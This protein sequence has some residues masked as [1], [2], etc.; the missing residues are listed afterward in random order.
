MKLVQRILLTFIAG[1]MPIAAFAVTD[2]ELEEARAI[3]TKQYLRYV[4]NGSDYLDKITVKSVAEL[5]PQLKTKE[6]ENI[7]AFKQIKVPGDY[8]S[9]DKSQLAE[10][11]SVTALETKGLNPEGKKAR[12]RI[13]KQINAMTVAPPAKEEPKKEEPKK[14]ET[15]QQPEAKETQEA[16]SPE[17][18]VAEHADSILAEAQLDALQAMEAEEADEPIKKEGSY[19][20]VYIL[21]LAVLVAIVIWLVVFAT[22]IL[23]KGGSRGEYV[24]RDYDDEDMAEREEHFKQVVDEKNSEINMLSKKLESA[25]RQNA[26]LKQKLEA[27]ATEVS[28]LRNR[29]SSSQAETPRKAPETVQQPQAERRREDQARPSNVPKSIFL[30]RANSKGIFVRADRK[31]N[32]GNSVFILHTNDGISG[33]F[34]VADNP[35]VWSHALRIPREYLAF[36]CIGPNIEDTTGV[37][38]I[39]NDNPGTAVFEGGCWRVTRKAR[40]HYEE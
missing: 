34:K 14:E 12:Q 29:L 9:W 33:T 3:A 7:K 11:W 32:P 39:V 17:A 30:G 37:S 23:K 22:N 6:K 26:E 16:V 20:W 5:E 35:E 18:A 28:A 36:A 19:T 21:S 1:F 38:K 24:P 13:K 10:F 27:L 31:L 15:P 40:I 8:K 4:N 25:N 2:K